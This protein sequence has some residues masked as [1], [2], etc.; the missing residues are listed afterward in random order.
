MSI[1][2]RDAECFD[3]L[4][5]IMKN[6]FYHRISQG[7]FCMNRLKIRA[8]LGIISF[9]FRE[10]MYSAW[11]RLNKRSFYKSM[12]NRQDPQKTVYQFTFKNV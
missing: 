6:Y 1:Y 10:T 12:I 5:K 4:K 3:K 9:K 8:E 7:Q 2:S 11:Q